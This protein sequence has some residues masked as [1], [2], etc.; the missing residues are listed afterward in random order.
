MFL[1]IKHVLDHFTSDDDK[2][3]RVSPICFDQEQPNSFQDILFLF[4]PAHYL[5]R[6]VLFYLPT[7]KIFSNKVSS[8]GLRSVWLDIYET[9]TI[10]I[11]V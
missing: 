11:G 4:E 5:L 6:V 1:Q 7:I 9:R 2:R 8:E 10:K 3:E